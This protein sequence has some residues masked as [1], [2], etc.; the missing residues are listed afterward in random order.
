MELVP[1]ADVAY[2]ETVVGPAND[3][4]NMDAGTGGWGPTRPFQLLFECGQVAV[5]IDAN[6]TIALLFHERHQSNSIN[7]TSNAFDFYGNQRS[8]AALVIKHEHRNK[9]QRSKKK[10]GARI[11]AVIDIAEQLAVLGAG[12]WKITRHEYRCA[13]TAKYGWAVFSIHDPQ[14]K[15]NHFRYNTRKFHFG[16]DRKLRHIARKLGAM[17]QS[18]QALQQQLEQKVS[19]WSQYGRTMSVPKLLMAYDPDIS[20]EA[21]LDIVSAVETQRQVHPSASID[22]LIK[23]AAAQTKQLPASS[24]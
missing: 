14:S 2:W 23:Q 16:V 18:P 3:G 12:G 6:D 11:K 15:E 4:S 19:D 20:S 5:I 8:M 13:T 10:I 1:K 9:S 22:D 7:S 17:P 21:M 24:R